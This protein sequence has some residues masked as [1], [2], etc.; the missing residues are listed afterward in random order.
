MFRDVLEAVSRRTLR[1]PG[2]GRSRTA[3]TWTGTVLA[4][5]LLC[6]PALAVPVTVQLRVEG[7]SSTIFEGPVT[8]DGKTIDKDAGPHPCD[9]TNGGANPSPGPT[10]TSALDDAAI[11]AGFTWDGNWAD[12]FGFE[13]FLIDRVGPDAADPATSR[14]WGIALNFAATQVGG[15]QQQ[16][17]AGDEVLFAYD[18]FSKSHLLKLTG[19]T[20]AAVGQP[21]TVAVTDGKDGSPI[22][23]AS[24][25]TAVTDSAGQATLG[26]DSPGLKRLKAE[27]ADSVRSNAFLVCVS[28]TGVE[29]CGVPVAQLGSQLG[30]VKRVR[31]S[32]APL[33][34]ISGPRNGATYRRGPRLLRGTASD[35]A[36]GV[37]VV[38]L[39]LRRHVP[40]RN[41]RWW[42]GRR[43]RFVG[44]HCHKVFFFAIGE[45]PAWSYLLPR[46]LP[47]GRYVLDVKAFDRE[48][49]RDERFER[50]RNRVVFQVLGRSAR[51]A[52][53][54]RRARRAARV[55][56]MV[57]GRERPLADA[58]TVRAR[59]LHVRASGRRCAVPASTPLAGLVV[60]LARSGTGYH[61]RD[62]GSCSARRS[63]SSAQLFVD[64][65]GSDRNRGQ[66][67]WFYKVNQRAGTAGAADPS[68]IPGR[69]LRGGDR[70]LWFYCKFDAGA[71]SCQRSLELL[72]PSVPAVAGETLPVQVRGYDNEGRA[73]PVEGVTVRLGS[74]TSLTDPAGRTELLPQP[75]RHLLRA[76]R[77]GSVPAFPL[78]IRVISR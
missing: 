74:A 75:G 3:I 67:G 68:G 52:H 9:G 78:P 42:S 8:T 62:F 73:R 2:A 34:R 27:K 25:G 38:K 53:S 71:G 21:L 61:L 18:F 31:D 39:A 29:N 10:M 5:L 23:G 20:T 4:L 26:F 64:R 77:P 45:D 22:E 48:R 19:A 70:V 11:A 58:E 41:C 12:E 76:E 36:S 32:R 57:V 66:D 49:N 50:G 7:A 47:R 44:N 6:P 56:V 72:V 69:R 54:S 40:G 24:V 35:D 60:R 28:Q 1:T 14:F 37:S 63:S 55:Q 65:V 51:P 15:C 16:V 33:A 17:Q 46:R 13:D 30:A 43:E 59:A